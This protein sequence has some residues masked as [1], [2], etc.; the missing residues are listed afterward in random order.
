MQCP[1]CKG[2]KTTIATHVRYADGSSRWGV[3]MKCLRCQGI[4]EVDDRTPEWIRIGRAMRDKRVNEDRRILRDE[5][6]RRG[7]DVVTLSQME[8][9]CIEPIPA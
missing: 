9:G 1:E 3:E 4:G 8:C 5:A 6:K 7:I 2:T